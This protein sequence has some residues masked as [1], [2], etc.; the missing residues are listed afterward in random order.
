MPGGWW[1]RNDGL[2]SDLSRCRVGPVLFLARAPSVG[3]ATRLE[4]RRCRTEAASRCR[5]V[6]GL[7]LLVL[8]F[9]GPRLNR[10]LKRLFLRRCQL[11]GSA[12]RL[13]FELNPI[14]AGPLSEG[15]P[16]GPAA[17]HLYW[18]G[19]GQRMEGEKCHALRDGHQPPGGSSIVA[20]RAFLHQLS[21]APLGGASG[22]SLSGLG[23]G[24]FALIFMVARSISAL[25]IRSSAGRVRS[26]VPTMASRCS[27][28]GLRNT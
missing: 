26:M 12:L 19:R 15:P 6:S 25:S 11:L 28:F 23:R 7:L 24:G 21:D 2:E 14:N 10:V 16:C 20:G 18:L 3:L 27:G 22:A 8:F 4:R 9:D 13:D 17:V 1:L 5:F